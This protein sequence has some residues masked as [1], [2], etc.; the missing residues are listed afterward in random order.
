MAEPLI[1]GNHL[2]EVSSCTSTND[3]LREMIGNSFQAE[4]AIL[5]TPHQTAG[6]GQIGTKWHS[7]PGDS[8]TF[9]LWLRPKFLHPSCQFLLNMAISNALIEYMRHHISSQSRIKWPND[10]YI[11]YKKSGGILIE[12]T[13]CS[14][15]VTGSIIGIGINLNQTVFPAELPHAISW[16]QTTGNNYQAKDVLQKLLPYL[17]AWYHLLRAE[18]YHKIKEEYARSLLG[19]D[20]L[21]YYEDAAGIF[22]GVI[23]G[24]DETGCLMIT[25]ETGERCQYGLK[26]IRFLFDGNTGYGV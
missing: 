2:M 23:S 14:H 11:G 15:Q 12:N 3:L 4:G 21:L 8:L 5:Y 19:I 6:R 25:K 24:V 16:K 1:I 10:L 22:K 18:A 13:I 7:Q 26:E 17:D 20:T 9:S